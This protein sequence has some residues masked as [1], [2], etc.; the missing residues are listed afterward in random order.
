MAQLRLKKESDMIAAEDMEW[1]GA[2]PTDNL[3]LWHA[4]IIG[5]DGTPYEGG[6]FNLTLKFP[7]TYPFKPPDV[8]FTTK[9][10]HPSIKKDSGEICADILKADWKPTL[11]VKWILSALHQMLKEPST[12]SP[13]E[14]EIAK[15]LQEKPEEFA[16]QAKAFTNKYAV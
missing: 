15:M 5:P 12:D 10:Y 2:E 11:N 14:P 1:G 9:I 3:F 7:D 6:L 16:K 4:S 13:L 8:L